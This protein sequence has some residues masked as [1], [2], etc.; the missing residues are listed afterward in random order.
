M[1]RV[2]ES[3]NNGFMNMAIDEAL[4]SSAKENPI[5]RFYDWQPSCVSLGYFQNYSD[6]NDGF[7]RSNGISIVRRLTGGRAIWHHPDEITYSVIVPEK[8]LGD[9]KESYQTICSW[10]V[11]ALADIGVQAEIKTNDIVVKGKKISGNAQTRIDGVLLQHGTI[12]IKNHFRMMASALSNKELD[13]EILK[14]AITSIERESG[15]PKE[16]FFEILKKRFLEGKE[17]EISALTEDEMRKAMN[18]VA[19]KYGTDRWNKMPGKE[20]GICYLI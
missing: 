7:C 18:L 19:T 10:I 5:I 9:I 8:I 16:T 11:A 17:W 3:K 2:I 15:L 6:I 1:W 14:R 12:I 13:T 4:M 20:R